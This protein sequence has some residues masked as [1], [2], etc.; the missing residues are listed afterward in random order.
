MVNLF[1]SNKRIFGNI[2]TKSLTNTQVTKDNIL[3][4]KEFLEKAGRD[5]VV[6][7]FIAGH[8]ILDDN[9]DYYY[10][11]Y[12]IDF[13]N[14]SLNGIEYEAIESLLDGIKALKKILFMDTCHSGEL[15]K[16]EIEIVQNTIKDT[17]E[18]RDNDR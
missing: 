13:D 2:Y 6:L 4:L 15:E 12:D 1:T 11:T 17:E 16:D 7:L 18:I 14:P 10:G 9:L 5:D 3:K 8:G